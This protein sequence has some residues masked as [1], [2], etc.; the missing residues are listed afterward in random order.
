MSDA[1]DEAGQEAVGAGGRGGEERHQSVGVAARP[2]PKPWSAGT[3]TLRAR[4]KV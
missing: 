1:E 2:P 4:Q 3:P